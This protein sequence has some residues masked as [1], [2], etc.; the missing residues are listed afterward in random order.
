MNL[1]DITIRRTRQ[2][3]LI[4]AIMLVMNT[5]NHLRRKRGMS[6]TRFKKLKQPPPLMV[7]FLKTDPEGS[8]VARDRKG[9][10]VGFAMSLIREDEW[11]LSLLFVD[12]TLQSKGLGQKASRQGHALRQEERL[13]TLGVGDIFLQPASYRSL[14]QDGYATA[15]TV[16]DDGTE[17]QRWTKRSRSCGLRSSSL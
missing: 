15:A 10:M 4:D 12:P 14:H 1:K 5:A 9:K 3:D 16:T 6:I 17:A 7:H 2:A 8:F 11:F 13:Q